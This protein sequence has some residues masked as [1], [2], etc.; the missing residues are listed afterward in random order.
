MLRKLRV[1][2]Q[3]NAMKAAAIGLVLVFAMSGTQASASADNFTVAK[4]ISDCQEALQIADNLVPGN[5]S[6]KAVVTVNA[7]R[8]LAFVRGVE[9]TAALI[10]GWQRRADKRPFEP[11]RKRICFPDNVDTQIRV[12]RRIVADV[13]IDPQTALENVE[14]PSVLVLNALTELYPCPK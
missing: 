1:S 8:C 13:A 11:L 3:G 10:Y 6:R 2:T 4:F 7:E 5:S 9:E 14:L 12:V